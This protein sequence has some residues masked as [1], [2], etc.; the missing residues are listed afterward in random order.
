MCCC[1]QELKRCSTVEEAAIEAI[2]IAGFAFDQFQKNEEDWG[3]LGYEV[4]LIP[5]FGIPG[6]DD[7]CAWNLSD[8]GHIVE[9]VKKASLT[10]RFVVV[11]K[12]ART[13]EEA[14]KSAEVL[15]FP[16]QVLPDKVSCLG[17]N[18]IAANEWELENAVTVALGV[19][20][21]SQFT[22]ASM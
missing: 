6:S 10:G 17:M 20:P 21:I 14:K 9:K 22:V 16:V 3:R 5:E 4:R 19:S 12:K 18:I 11:I 1:D 13:Y 2:R 7:M 8:L 15:G